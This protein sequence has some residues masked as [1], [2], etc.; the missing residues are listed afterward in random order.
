[1]ELEEL[2]RSIDIVEFISQFVELEQRGDEWW[3]LSPFKDEKTPS[4]SVR[5]NPP[6]WFDY[7]SGQGGNVYSFVKA[8]A[9]H[10]KIGVYY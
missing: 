6:F 4:F 7:S 1:M 2:I 3:G 5:P 10:I 9:Q 8:Y